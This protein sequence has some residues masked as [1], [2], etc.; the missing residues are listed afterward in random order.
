MGLVADAELMGYAAPAL[1]V[2]ESAATEAE[3]QV[4]RSWAGM[5]SGGRILI[6]IEQLAAGQDVNNLVSHETV[7]DVLLHSSFLGMQQLAL[8]VFG[9]PPWPEFSLSVAVRRTLGSTVRASV[10][11][12]EACA[13]FLPSL[14]F[15]ISALAAY[16][17]SLTPGYREVLQS[18]EWLRRTN[19]EPDLMTKLVFSLGRFSLGIRLPPATLT[20]GAEL[21]AFLSDGKHNP[22]ERF[23]A[24]SAALER[25][26][27]AD[28]AALARVESPELEIAKTWYAR[29]VGEGAT[30]VAPPEPGPAWLG[31]WRELVSEMV[32]VWVDDRRVNDKD[33][34][35][36]R[37]TASHSELLL[38]PPSASVLKAVLT[39]TVSTSGGIADHPAIETLLP[40]E[41]A[42][43]LYNGYATPVPGIEKVNNTGLP[44][45]PTEAAIWVESPSRESA[46][47][48]LSDAELRQFVSS[49]PADTTICVYDA[50]YLFP[51]G[52]VLADAPLIL[53]RSHVV[54]VT[55]RSLGGL[56]AD[57]LLSTG[58][59]GT[60]ELH[61]AVISGE[62]PGA[63]YFLAA[64]ATKA[65]PVLVVPAPWPTV[66]RARDDLRRSGDHAL[67]WT[68]IAPDAFIKGARS[69]DLIRLFSWFEN[70]PWPAFLVRQPDVPLGSVAVQDFLDL[71]PPLDSRDCAE[72]ALEQ[73]SK[74][75]RGQLD[76]AVRLEARGKVRRAE[77]GYKKMIAMADPEM[78]A[79]G[80]IALG[81]MLARR[82]RAQA[83]F[84]SYQPAIQSGH[85]DLAPLA[86]LYMAQLLLAM[87]DVAGAIQGFLIVAKTR[88][89]NHG[90]PAAYYLGELLRATGRDLATQ[91]KI[92]KWV[93][94]SQH[95]AVSPLAAIELAQI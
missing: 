55:S 8:S 26:R 73:L 44:L 33:R 10:K 16:S 89:P 35:T 76:E 82:G 48:R 62:T 28:L 87:G 72:D 1:N 13:T 68:E 52:D 66:A 90:P 79:A 25:G 75:V 80:S 57:P 12:Q 95:P 23:A 15:E 74:S 9:Y 86:G 36:L 67:G 58:L 4:A 22:N 60:S 29:S 18:L 92:F 39:H 32:Q 11:V 51:L 6:S 21:R 3:L 14:R 50:T 61:Y 47:A 17:D 64:P 2:E 38:Q 7:H 78:R 34:E 71:G 81:M 54:L 65:Y 56:L 24:A 93:V 45:A 27:V 88:H 46:A 31:R 49:A 42:L 85:P 83:A 19:L 41:L 43:V 37:D 53:T 30:Y 70:K 5:T 77:T 69:V 20:G 84:D 63:A 94:D 91:R 40:Y 59:A